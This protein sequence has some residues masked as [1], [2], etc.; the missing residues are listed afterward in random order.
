MQEKTLTTHNMRV[1]NRKQ[2]HNDRNFN[3]EQDKHIDSTLSEN[4]IYW[5]WRKGLTFE[6]CEKAFYEEE[7]GPWLDN[8]NQNNIKTG[9]K[10]R[11]KTIDDLL[12][13]KRYAPIE[14][15]L[16]IGNTDIGSVSIDTYKTIL[17]NYMEWIKENYP[18][19][20]VLDSAIHVDEPNATPHIH[21]R[22]TVEAITNDGYMMPNQNKGLEQSGISL[23]NPNAKIDRYNN[24][25]MTFTTT[26]RDKLKELCKEQDIEVIQGTSKGGQN[27]ANY[28][29]NKDLERQEIDK[30]IEKVLNRLKRLKEQEQK[31]LERLS[32]QKAQKEKELKAL[33]VK[34][35]NK[36]MEIDAKQLELD[37]IKEEI[38]TKQQEIKDI[39]TKQRNIN[40]DWY[41]TP[42]KNNLDNW[43][44]NFR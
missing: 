11:T 31:E 2:K 44:D 38:R 19:V 36:Q 37:D 6:E 17:N 20:I 39:E 5:T 13:S 32:L 43:I 28:K 3:S 27:L 40:K 35:Q 24:R 14:T 26:L 22:W 18:N 30:E 12:T 1:G 29:H 41:G 25:L 9:H 21:I 15:I 8:Q 10:E 7:Y 23:P 16:T 33:S 42:G 34:S 4:N